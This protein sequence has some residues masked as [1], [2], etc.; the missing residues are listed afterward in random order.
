[1]LWC[2]DMMTGWVMKAFNVSHFDDRRLCFKRTCDETVIAFQWDHA[3]RDFQDPEYRLSTVC[4]EDG[5][6][7][8]ASGRDEDG[9]KCMHK[10]HT[11]PI[12]ASPTVDEAGE[13]PMF[14]GPSHRLRSDETWIKE[15]V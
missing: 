15:P 13:L 6:C 2:A 11:D 12:C 4:C 3:V 9:L 8:N 1:M 5:Q 7:M 14:K 10:L